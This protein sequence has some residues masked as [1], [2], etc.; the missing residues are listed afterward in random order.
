MSLLEVKSGL[1]ALSP[2][3]WQKSGRLHVST[4]WLLQ[5]L[6]LGSYARTVIIDRKRRRIEVGVR[7]LWAWTRHRLIPFASI[8]HIGYR[9]GSV[10]TSL[11]SID[12]EPT[13]R[14]ERFVVELVLDGGERVRVASFRGEGSEMTGLGD[15]LLGDSLV[16]HAGDQEERSRSFI[17]QLMDITGLPLGKR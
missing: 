1:L 9:Y 15:V 14:V 11:S 6:T 5:L 16:D 8:D 13:D 2:R 17:E 10:A 7:F 4:N 12:A 3:I